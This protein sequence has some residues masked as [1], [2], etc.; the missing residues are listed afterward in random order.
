MS[1]GFGLSL[2]KSK[3]N[4]NF[5]VNVKTD[6]YKIITITVITKTQQNIGDYIWRYFIDA[7]L[8]AITAQSAW[9]GLSQA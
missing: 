2:S 3:K 8:P 7:H 5:N 1:N 4:N 9:V 6:F